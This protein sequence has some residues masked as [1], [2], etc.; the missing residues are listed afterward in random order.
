MPN[1]WAHIQFGREVLHE[2]EPGFM[3]SDPVWK[4]AFQ[5]GCQGPDFLFYHHFLPWQSATPLNRLGSQMHSVR[6]GPF[7]MS[8]F[9]RVRERD[10]TDSA[11]AF[12]IGFLLH[13]ILDRYL[14]PFVFSRSGF[15]KW[16]HQRFETAMDSVVLERRAGIHTGNTPVA[17]EIDTGGRMPG[18]FAADFLQIVSLHY[19]VLAKQINPDE[20]DEAVAQMVTAQKLFFDPSDWKGKLLLGQIEP[21]SPPRRLPAWD[22]LNDTRQPW[23]D[24]CDRTLV[25]HESADDLWEEALLDGKRTA[26]AGIAWLQA[27]PGDTVHEHKFAELLKDISYETGRPC[28]S[29]SI[30]YAESVVPAAQ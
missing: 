3:M 17:P 29:A 22:V 24:P 21:F 9:S 14:H 2:L 15:K 13:H 16:D 18:D 4:K 30:I 10:V 5:L 27:E 1:I 8:L 25:R 20:I 12:T 11:S 7:L 6:C 26:A 28:G 23:I 19:P